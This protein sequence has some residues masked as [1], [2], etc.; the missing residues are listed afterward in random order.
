MGA[1]GARMRRVDEAVRE[2]LG[3]AVTHDEVF[4]ARVHQNQAG[5]DEE[6]VRPRRGPEIEPEQP[7][8]P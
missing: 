1:G 3:D 4:Q 6:R 2:V 8:E 7:K 5:R